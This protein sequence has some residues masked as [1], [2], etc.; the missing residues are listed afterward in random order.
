[1]LQKMY[2]LVIISNNITIILSY[3]AL[4]TYTLARITNTLASAANNLL[5]LLLLGNVILENLNV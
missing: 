4:L 5:V 2:I 3:H 1:M